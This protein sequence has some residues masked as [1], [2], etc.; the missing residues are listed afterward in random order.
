M[1][2]TSPLT[3]Q[4]LCQNT[5]APNLAAQPFN[6]LLDMAKMLMWLGE[7]LSEGGVVIWSGDRGWS[8]AGAGNAQLAHL[9][10]ERRPEQ[11]EPGGC[12]GFATESSV[13]FPRVRAQ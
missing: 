3:W 1:A 10:I 6:V 12:T 7:E 9:V 13:G 2:V 5:P 11:A 4:R 8:R